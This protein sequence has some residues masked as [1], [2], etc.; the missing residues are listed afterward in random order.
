[1]STSI[2]EAFVAGKGCAVLRPIDVPPEDDMPFYL[3]MNCIKTYDEFRT[4]FC[5]EMQETAINKELLSQYYYI[6]QDRF[7]FELV[8]DAIEKILHDDSYLLDKPMNYSLSGIFNA[9]RLKNCLKR[10]VD[11]M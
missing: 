5:A 1:M 10:L 4:S 2:V 3:G 6:P 8:C 9:E 11:I 7:S